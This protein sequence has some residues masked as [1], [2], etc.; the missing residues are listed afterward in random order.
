MRENRKSGTVCVGA[1]NRHPV[2]DII[3]KEEDY[4]EVY[5]RAGLVPIK[6]YRPLAKEEEPYSWSETKIAPW[7]IYVLEQGKGVAADVYE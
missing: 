6:T 7:I 1:G 4:H 2:E 5:R 3:W